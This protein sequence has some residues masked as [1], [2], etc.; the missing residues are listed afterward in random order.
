[1]P[2]KELYF[3]NLLFCAYKYLRFLL[4]LC[5][6]YNN[7]YYV[8]AHIIMSHTIIITMMMMVMNIWERVSAPTLSHNHNHK[9]EQY[10]I[11]LLH[12]STLS[13]ALRWPFF[14]FGWSSDAAADDD[15]VNQRKNFHP[16]QYHH[17]TQI[18]LQ[19][20]REDLPSNNF[21]W[22]TQTHTK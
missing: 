9:E 12:V 13:A 3:A 15:V 4:G 7:K 17:N 18:F 19:R 1:M 20:E 14:L 21:A 5:R 11:T 22:C 8:N 2:K 16:I 6:R 10:I